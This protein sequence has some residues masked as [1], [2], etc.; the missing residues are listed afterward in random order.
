VDDFI[1][2]TS[3][4]TTTATT[5]EEEDQEKSIYITISVMMGRG[6]VEDGGN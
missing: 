4:T 3:T 5:E 6:R 1:P 2:T